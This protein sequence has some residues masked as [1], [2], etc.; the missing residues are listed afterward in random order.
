MLNG[1]TKNWSYVIFMIYSVAEILIKPAGFSFTKPVGSSIVIT[2]AISDDTNRASV[3]WFDK[4][5]LEVTARS[6]R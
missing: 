2:C 1:K 5:N 6:G 3:R 4:N